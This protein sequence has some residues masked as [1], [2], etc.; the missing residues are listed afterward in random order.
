MGF[1]RKG[2]YVTSPIL[3]ILR[4]L[5]HEIVLKI[6]YWAFNSLLVVDHFQVP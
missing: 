2:K 4:Y 5:I 6:L 3:R 1:L